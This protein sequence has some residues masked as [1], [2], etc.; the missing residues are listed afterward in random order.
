MENSDNKSPFSKII[1][2]ILFAIVGF[3]VFNLTANGIFA[4]KKTFQKDSPTEQ[5]TESSES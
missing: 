1:A 5:I 3:I 2:F 4:L